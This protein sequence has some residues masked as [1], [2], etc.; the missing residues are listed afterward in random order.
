MREEHVIYT[1]VDITDTG[2]SNPTG[3]TSEFRQAQNLNSL[4]QVMSMRTQPLDI[5]LTVVLDASLIDHKFGTSFDDS[6]TIWRLSFATDTTG[7]WASGDDKHVHLVN[8]CNNV[9]VYVGLDETVEL[10]P[11]SFSAVDDE[12]KNIYFI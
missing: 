1:L 7:A 5:V 4:L 2:S 10:N 12:I 9:P 11:G 3:N 6:Q 8:D